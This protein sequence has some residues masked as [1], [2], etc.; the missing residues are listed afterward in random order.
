MSALVWA[1]NFLIA[2]CPGC[3]VSGCWLFVYFVS[4]SLCTV[5]R[6]YG[7]LH[8]STLAKV[9]CVQIF[10]QLHECWLCAM[11]YASYGDWQ[12]LFK[13]IQVEVEG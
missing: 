2:L 9:A 12:R 7:S 10:V 6:Y 5:S 13:C 1:F 4:V 8:L 3:R 11:T